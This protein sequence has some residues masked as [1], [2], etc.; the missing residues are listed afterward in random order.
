LFPVFNLIKYA[1]FAFSLRYQEPD[2]DENNPARA[3]CRGAIRAK[4]MRKPRTIYSIWQLQV[5]NR[6]F[7][8]SQY[9]NLT[10]RA[11][12]ASQLGLTSVKKPFWYLKYDLVCMLSIT[13][14]PV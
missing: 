7:A 3:P 4:K 11:S 8:H 13:P 6:R 5:L 9:L 14:N 10:E 1:L 2:R 12:L